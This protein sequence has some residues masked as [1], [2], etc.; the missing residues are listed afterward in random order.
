MELA[1]TST[2][3]LNY[4]FCVLSKAC[5]GWSIQLKLWPKDYCN[6]CLKH[7][8]IHKLLFFLRPVLTEIFYLKSNKITEILFIFLLVYL[9]VTIDKIFPAVLPVKT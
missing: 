3:E 8:C 6:K 5:K 4:P 1:L 9:S 7:N 2:S